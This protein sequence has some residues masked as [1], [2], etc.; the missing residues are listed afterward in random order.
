MHQ[1]GFN[2]MSEGFWTLLTFFLSRRLFVA[3]RETVFIEGLLRNL[4]KRRKVLNWQ[5][6]PDFNL[7]VFCISFSSWN[8]SF[9]I[10]LI[11]PCLHFFRLFFHF[12]GGLG[13]THANFFHWK[14]VQVIVGALGSALDLLKQQ[15]DLTRWGKVFFG[16][17]GCCD[18]WAVIKTRGYLLS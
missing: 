4:W 6:V 14:F 18:I 11:F 3:E 12:S 5:E 13:N 8:I 10:V 16:Q 17:P 15:V 7:T 1:A 2:G 9:V